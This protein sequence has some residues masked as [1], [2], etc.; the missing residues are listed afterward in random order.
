MHALSHHQTADGFTSYCLR[1]LY[2]Q[3]PRDLQ[4]GAGKLTNVDASPS[5]LLPVCLLT[6]R[7]ISRGGPWHPGFPF[8]FQQHGNRN[9]VEQQ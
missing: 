6:C 7:A 9:T 1:S 4:I 5:R 8:K 2:L 3:I